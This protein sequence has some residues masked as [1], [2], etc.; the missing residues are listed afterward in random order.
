MVFWEDSWCEGWLTKKTWNATWF[1]GKVFLCEG[2]LAKKVEMPH[3]FLGRF[4]V[5]RSTHK[6]KLKS[7]MVFWEG[8]LVR[9]STHKKS[10]E[11]PHGFLG[12]FFGAKV[13]SQKK[14]ETPHGFLGRFFGAK[15]D[16]QKKLE[17]PH[18]FLGRFLV[19]RSTHKK[20]TCQVAEGF[21]KSLAVETKQKN[22]SKCHLFFLVLF[23]GSGWGVGFWDVLAVQNNSQKSWQVTWSCWDARWWLLGGVGFFGS[24]LWRFIHKKLAKKHRSLPT[25][26]LPRS[27]LSNYFCPMSVKE[28][29]YMQ[30]DGAD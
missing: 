30:V 23:L 3:G 19:R 8:S 9:R 22:N 11:T 12:R 25:L 29:I 13:D 27:S 14:L 16:S 20:N 15:V 6:K 10:L 2:R 28:E 1:S 24:W 18:G 17:T 5:G 26:S 4:L 7:H 21:W